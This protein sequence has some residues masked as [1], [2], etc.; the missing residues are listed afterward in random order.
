MALK[1]H[2]VCKAQSNYVGTRKTAS[3]CAFVRLNKRSFVE[4]VPCDVE[5]LRTAASY[6]A[7]R[8]ELGDCQG[9]SAYV[10]PGR[11]VLTADAA[12]R[13]A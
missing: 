2:S 1:S 10:W 5:V 9:G 3:M 6:H 13:I 4:R 7:E 11:P 8:D 12:N